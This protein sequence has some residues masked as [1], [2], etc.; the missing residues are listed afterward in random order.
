LKTDGRLDVGQQLLA[1]AG[2]ASAE[3]MVGFG[4]GTTAPS[5]LFGSA[6]DTNLYRS[7]AD[8]LKTDDTFMAVGNVYGNYGNSVQ[9]TIGYDFISGL[10]GIGF[11]T[12]NDTSLYRSAAGQLKTDGYLLAASEIV[13]SDGATASKTRIGAGGIFFGTAAGDT[14]LYRSAAGMLQTDGHL[15]AVGQVQS[16]RGGTGQ[17][18]LSTDSGAPSGNARIFFGSALDT[19]LYRSAAAILKTDGQFYTTSY[20]AAFAGTANESALTQAG[21]AFAMGDTNLYRLAAGTLKTD[22]NLVVA[23]V[24]EMDGQFRSNTIVG[25]VVGG[26]QVGK[27]PIYNVSGALVGYI[28]IYAT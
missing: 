19:N 11:G 18:A 23:G 12:L 15:L 5:I 7:A 21:I 2:H 10:P 13:A 3:V 25:A 27:Q 24:F 4:G 17:I 6:G 9:V 26:A 1:N 22:G 20:I 16:M 14:N 28:P 8:T